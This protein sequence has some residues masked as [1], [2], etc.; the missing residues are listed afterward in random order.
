[1]GGGE[2][3]DPEV[4]VGSSSR[5][6][7]AGGWLTKADCVS[8]VAGEVGDVEDLRAGAGMDA[9]LLRPTTDEDDCDAW[10][11]DCGRKECVDAD[12][13]APR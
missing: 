13:S 9:R 11:M 6:G 8:G 7:E 4:E 3:V 10:D 5:I 1:M 12:G 2:E